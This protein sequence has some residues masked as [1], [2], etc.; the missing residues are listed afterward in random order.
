MLNELP[1][2]NPD[3]YLKQYFGDIT[4]VKIDGKRRRTEFEF[5]NTKTGWTPIFDKLLKADPEFI[6]NGIEFFWAREYY[7]TLYLKT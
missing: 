4:Y 2:D 3:F 5:G 6:P 1:F 7:D